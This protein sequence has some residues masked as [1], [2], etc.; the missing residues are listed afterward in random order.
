[1]VI[2]VAILTFDP[3]GK[4]TIQRGTVFP[5]CYISN[6]QPLLMPLFIFAPRCF[7][8]KLRTMKTRSQT[9][10]QA[11]KWIS[12][13]AEIRLMIL[14]AIAYQ[15]NSGWASLASVCREW[16]HVLEKANYYKM[17]LGVSCLDNFESIASTQKR[18]LIHHICLDFELPRYTPKC[19][20][21]RRIPP[22]R[23]DSIVSNGISRLLSILSSWSPSNKLALEI[24]VFSPS[25]C[26]HWFKNLYLSSDDV[27]YGEDTMSDTWRTGTGYHDPRHGWIHGQQVKAPPYPVMER[28]FRRIHLV[29][30]EMLPRVEAVNCL[31]IRRQLRRRLSPKSIGM[32]LSKFDRLEYMSYE[33]WAPYKTQGREFDDR[34]THPRGHALAGIAISFSHHVNTR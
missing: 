29:L 9:R 22:V 30:P 14:E 34:G 17:K 16:Q 27:E 1:M 33:P 12:L 31:I 6:P 25:D 13:P 20:S 3:A 7:S 8:S 21:K 11:I 28:L 23:I 32:L 5:D 26:E 2:K 4:N 15:K 18:A 10:A 24:N 19:C